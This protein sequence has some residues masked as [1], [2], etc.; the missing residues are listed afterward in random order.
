MERGNKME[1]AEQNL[2]GKEVE[3][4]TLK[5]DDQHGTVESIG[6]YGITILLTDMRN[7]AQ[8][9]YIPWHRVEFI[10]IVD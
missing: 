7:K 2:I 10:W 5:D 9:S 4:E 3:V 1:K 6:E 8:H